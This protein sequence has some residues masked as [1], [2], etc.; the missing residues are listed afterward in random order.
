M[1]VQVG[2]PYA[3]T[4]FPYLGHPMNVALHLYLGMLTDI[5]RVFCLG[6][7]GGRGLKFVRTFFARFFVTL[8]ASMC[9]SS[10]GG[11]AGS[12]RRFGSSYVIWE[13]TVLHSKD[14]AL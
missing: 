13:E 7:T 9:G 3:N 12:E 6:E 8:C 10:A 11:V 1:L 4:S 5:H 2:P 14:T